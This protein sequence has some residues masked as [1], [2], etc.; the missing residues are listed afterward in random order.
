[1][2]QSSRG[3]AAAVGRKPASVGV[4]GNVPFSELKAPAFQLV[5]LLW[6]R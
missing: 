6:P 3:V 4:N 5:G 2:I 1:L